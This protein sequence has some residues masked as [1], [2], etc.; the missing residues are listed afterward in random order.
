MNSYVEF[1]IKASSS[2]NSN[3]SISQIST[4]ICTKTSRTVD[5]M[6][7]IKIIK[8]TL[9]IQK[10]RNRLNLNTNTLLPRVRNYFHFCSMRKFGAGILH[11]V[12]G[13]CKCHANDFLSKSNVHARFNESDK[14]FPSLISKTRH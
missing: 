6:I 12:F 7:E 9:V 1:V 8:S 2:L 13:S 10:F 3:F 4:N 11:H 5:P 14:P